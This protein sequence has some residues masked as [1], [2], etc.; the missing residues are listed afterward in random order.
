M[1]TLIW[2]N[3]NYYYRVDVAAEL[4]RGKSEKKAENAITDV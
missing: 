4:Y 1:E 2:Y 3:P